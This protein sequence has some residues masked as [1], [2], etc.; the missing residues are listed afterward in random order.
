MFTFFTHSKAILTHPK[1]IFAQ[2]GPF[3]NQPGGF[4]DQP[5]PFLLTI[6]FSLFDNNM[7]TENDLFKL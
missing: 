1:G 4:F 6:D 2:P 3:F 5:M 7:P